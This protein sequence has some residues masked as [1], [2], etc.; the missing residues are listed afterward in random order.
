MRYALYKPNSKSTGCAGSFA[1]TQG[2]PKNLTNL[3]VS[4]VQQTG[5]NSE[6]KIGS[7]KGGKSINIKFSHNEAGEILSSIKTRIPFVAFHTF[8]DD[9]TTIRFSPWDKKQKVKTRNGEVTYDTPAWGLSVTKNG[10]E[11]YRLSVDAGEAEVIAILLKD[12]IENHLAESHAEYENN[13]SQAR[14]ENTRAN[15][16][17]E[18][19]QSSDEDDDVP[20]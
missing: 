8:N 3:Y 12:F 15:T 9:Q 14:N 6:K 19:Q 11:T 20:F 18:N 5:W 13:K 4:L 10:S 2:G 7:F 1:V 16:S 17:Q